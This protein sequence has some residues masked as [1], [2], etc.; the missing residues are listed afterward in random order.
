MQTSQKR[1]AD[2]SL[3]WV[4]AEDSPWCEGFRNWVTAAHRQTPGEPTWRIQ[5]VQHDTLRLSK[6]P[7]RTNSGPR[8][9]LEIIV[10]LIDR[11]GIVDVFRRIA[12]VQRTRPGY[13][14][15]S[16]G[17]VSPVEQRLLSEVGVKGHVQQPHHWNQLEGLLSR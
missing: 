2:L 3:W 11:Q 15:L 12:V 5:F 1:T 17:L 9:G 14:H 16:T 6:L 4:G 8:G 13:L 7:H 10:W